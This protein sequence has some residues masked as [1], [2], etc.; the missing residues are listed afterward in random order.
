VQSDPSVKVPAE[1]FK[2]QAGFLHAV[3]N[4]LRTLNAVVRR[5]KDETL[6]VTGLQQ[7][8][9][10]IAKGAALEEKTEALMK[11]LLAIDDEL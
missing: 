5:I 6:Q 2:A 9:D 1:A 8:G 7:R 4:D 10:A 11:K 3:R